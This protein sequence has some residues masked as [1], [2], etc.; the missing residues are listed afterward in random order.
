M[1]NKMKMRGTASFL[2]LLLLASAPVVFA[3]G[4]PKEPNSSGLTADS[5]ASSSE[6]KNIDTYIA[7]LRDNVRQQSAQI[8]GAVMQLSPEESK[9]FWPLYDEYQTALVTLNDLRIQNLTNYATAFAELTDEK[10]DQ[11]IKQELNLRKQ[12]DELLARSYER[13]KQSL[14]A[15]TAARFLLIES[16]LQLIIDL[17]LDSHLPIGG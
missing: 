3:G 12:R 15:L 9:K 5:K 13:V 6:K 16:Q 2:L 10:A 1:H 11:L 7:L 8:T 4:G 14:G 17:Q